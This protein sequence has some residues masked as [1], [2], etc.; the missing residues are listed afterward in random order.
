MEAEGT[1]L[2][3]EGMVKAVAGSNSLAAEPAAK[4]KAHD[5]GSHE[6]DIRWRDTPICL[7]VLAGR[8]PVSA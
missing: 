6:T 1:G 2:E 7:C 5:L 3:L 4:P 8:Q